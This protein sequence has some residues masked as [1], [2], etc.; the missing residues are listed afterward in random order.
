M[1][2][3]AMNDVRLSVSSPMS[4]IVTMFGC[5]RIPAVCAS[6]TKRSRNSRDSESSSLGLG[7]ADGLDRD[8]PADD[9][10][11]GEV[12]HAHGSLAELVQDLVTAQLGHAR[13]RRHLS[14]HRFGTSPSRPKTPRRDTL[15]ERHAGPGE[16]L[17]GWPARE[18]GRIWPRH[19]LA[20]REEGPSGRAYPALH[21]TERSRRPR[22][23]PSPKTAPRGP[24]RTASASRNR[25]RS[26]SA[27]RRWPS[28]CG[29]PA[30]ISTW[31]RAGSWPRAS[32][33]GPTSI[34]RIEHCRE[35]R[36]PEEEGNVV[37]VR[38][39]EPARGPRRARAAHARSRPPPA[40]SAARARSSRSAASFPAIA[41]TRASTP[42]ILRGLPEPCAAPSRA[43]PRRA[44]STPPASSRCRASCS[45][46]R[47][48]IGRHNAVD[49]A[50][51]PLFR[52]GNCP[53][54][55]DPPR[56]RPRLL[57]DRPEGAG[58]RR[59]RSS[60]RS[61]R[62]RRSPSTSPGSRR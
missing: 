39:T 55:D 7:V 49:K 33:T 1:Y 9:R 26:A 28:R 46:C 47:E 40:A 13:S 27:P 60:P 53:F 50:I 56:L 43:S 10:V 58:R 48:D 45:S 20:T 62:R 51:G 31:P 11:L 41:R 22:R 14:R 57:R 2:S 4:W 34:V 61:R 32:C 59:S 12:D 29:R 52:E 44:D 3:I 17:A 15:A 35:V 19:G 30:T 24:A 6:R 37:I 38:T 16:I 25:S 8:E 5:D 18:G 21:G 42:A 23:L 54:R 36:S